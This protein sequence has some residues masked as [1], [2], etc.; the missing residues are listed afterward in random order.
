MVESS[1]DGRLAW[2][3]GG[4]R[5]TLGNIPQFDNWIQVRRLSPRLRITDRTIA[6]SWA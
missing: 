3:G 4:V 6:D 1:K 2:L 5:K